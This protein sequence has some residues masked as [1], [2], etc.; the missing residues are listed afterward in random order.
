[1][2]SSYSQMF[3]NTP[4][5]HCE[6]MNR[7]VMDNTV[8]DQESVTGFGEDKFKVIAIYK[9]KGEKIVEVYFVR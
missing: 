2:R 6:L 1:M 7:M 3:E 5:L 9:V 8:I 4:N